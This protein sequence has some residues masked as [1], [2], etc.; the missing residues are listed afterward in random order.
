MSFTT[1]APLTALQAM[2]AATTGVQAA[3]IGAPESFSTRVSAYV[4]VAGQRII[5]KAGGLLQREADYFCAFGY[6]VAG[7][8]AT[9]ETTLA[10]A[11]DS[12]VAA[13][14][15]ARAARTGLFAV[16]TTQVLSGTLDLSLASA[17]EYRTVAGQEY[18]ILPFLVTVTQQATI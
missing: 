16:A 18:R 3:Q 8:E 17:P 11:V 12:F 10:A 14:Y 6:R 9:A 7:A 4:T 5:D 15:A 1:S 2:E 13:F